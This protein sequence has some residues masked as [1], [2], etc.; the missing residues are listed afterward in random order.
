[1]DLVDEQLQNSKT[2]AVVGLSGDPDR[3]SFRVT[4]YMQEQGYRIIPVNPMIEEVLGEKSYPDLKSV[5]EPIDMVNIF[6]RCEV[7]ILQSPAAAYSVQ[8]RKG[9]APFNL[10]KGRRDR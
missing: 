1:M 9:T 6:R 7:K 2:I 8:V 4:R 5:P 3:I 10:K